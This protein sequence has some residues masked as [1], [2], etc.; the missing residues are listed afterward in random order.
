MKIITLAIILG[1]FA[2]NGVLACERAADRKRDKDESLTLCGK[3]REIALWKRNDKLQFIRFVIDFEL[4]NDGSKPAIVIPKKL[5]VLSGN[6]ITPGGEHGASFSGYAH[7][8]STFEDYEKVKALFDTPQPDPADTK[9]IGPN[10]VVTFTREVKVDGEPVGG[11]VENIWSG[12]K[13]NSA[14]T[15]NLFL[16]TADSRLYNAGKIFKAESFWKGLRNRWEKS[17]IL[18]YHDLESEPIPLDL[19]AVL[20]KTGDVDKISR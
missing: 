11:V 4:K 6:A 18:V 20:I 19:R 5:D 7:W 2:V 10:E 8:K 12:M 1:V 17:G 3:V 14:Y 9:V 15:L 13:R 16:Q